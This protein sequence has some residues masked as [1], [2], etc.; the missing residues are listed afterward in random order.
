MTFKLAAGQGHQLQNPIQLE[1][2]QR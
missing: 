1:F 2:L